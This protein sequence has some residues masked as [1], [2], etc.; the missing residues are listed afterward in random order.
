M[1]E[2][3]CEHTMHGVIG[4]GTIEVKCK[5]N[6]CGARSGVIVLHKF[7]LSSGKLISTNRYTDPMRKEVNK[8]GTRR[9]RISLRTA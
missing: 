3:R 8:H 4:D 1:M 6:R 5:N 9:D 7:S 2:F